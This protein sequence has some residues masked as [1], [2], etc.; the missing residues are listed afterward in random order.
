VHAVNQVPWASDVPVLGAL[1]KSSDWQKN[2][3]ELVIIVTP[4][5]TTPVDHVDQLPNPLRGVDEP[6]AIDQIL[7]GK[8]FDAPKDPPGAMAQEPV[9]QAA[10]LPANG[11]A[12]AVPFQ[13]EA[14]A[15]TTDVAA[16]QSTAAAAP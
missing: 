2:Q 12:S 9:A 14:A 5:L 16:A 15:P 6:S 13:S 4:R 11:Q 10:P 3:T 8:G 7:M 1:F